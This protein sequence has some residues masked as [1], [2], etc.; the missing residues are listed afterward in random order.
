MTQNSVT[1][2]T[3]ESTR[4]NNLNLLKFIAAIFV[5]ISHAF[6]LSKGAEYN[7]ILSDLSRNS[8]AFGSL[9]VA[10]FFMSSGFFVTKS[11]LKNK[12]SKSIFIIDL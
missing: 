10:I 5:I 8:I 7:D 2:K 11:L 3:F 4:S 9:A 6:P 1:L 12:N